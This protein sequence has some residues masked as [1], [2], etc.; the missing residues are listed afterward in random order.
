MNPL[1]S[2]FCTILPILNLI[3]YMWFFFFFL[4]PCWQLSKEIICLIDWYYTRFII[5]NLSQVL[6]TTLL[7]PSHLLFYV[8]RSYCSDAIFFGLLTYFT[9]TFTDSKK[10]CLLPHV[11]LSAVNFPQFPISHLQHSC[12][13]TPVFILLRR[14]FIVRS[15]LPSFQHQF[16]FCVFNFVHSSHISEHKPLLLSHWH[17]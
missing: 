17:Y 8:P 10:S 9:H 1:T 15:S 16:S 6:K 11:R 12:I 4:P 2:I 13:S 3:V 7:L 5:S 14:S